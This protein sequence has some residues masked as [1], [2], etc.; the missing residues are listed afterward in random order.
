MTDLPRKPRIDKRRGH[1][2]SDPFREVRGFYDSEIAPL[3]ELLV[4]DSLNNPLRHSLRKYLIV[5]IFAALDYFFR[6]SVKNLVDNNGLSLGPLFAPESHA[7][8]D[9][10]VKESGVT[11]GS[12]VASTY[13]FVDI[14][15]IDFVFSNLLQINS[16]LD[17]IIKLND[18]NQTRY[19]LDGHPLPI[20]YE[21]L[22]KAYKLRNDIAHEIK[23]VKISII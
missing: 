10:F 12:I 14:L 2:S 13:R 18:I 23:N 6:N 21:K 5:A 7:K 20:E 15:E 17:Y 8:L 16:F 19:V 3:F 4:D 9:G 1:I 22:T 11:K